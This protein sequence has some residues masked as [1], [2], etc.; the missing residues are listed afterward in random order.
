MD[1]GHVTDIA[2]MAVYL[3]HKYPHT[4]IP[5]LNSL[6]T[7]GESFRKAKSDTRQE[8]LNYVCDEVLGRIDQVE[9][10]G[11]VGAQRG[12]KTKISL[13]AKAARNKTSQKAISKSKNE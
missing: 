13:A 10:A 12:I 4:T 3:A 9:K 2:V 11:L 8:N 5:I 7:A 1:S 6:G